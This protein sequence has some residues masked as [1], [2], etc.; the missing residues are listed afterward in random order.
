MKQQSHLQRTSLLMVMVRSCWRLPRSNC[1]LFIKN[2]LYVIIAYIFLNQLPQ[3]KIYCQTTLPAH[4]AYPRTARWCGDESSS[5]EYCSQKCQHTCCYRGI[6]ETFVEPGIFFPIDETCVV[7][8]WALEHVPGS[9][10]KAYLLTKVKSF[11]AKVYMKKCPNQHC[12]ARHS[13]RTWR[14]GISKHCVVENYLYL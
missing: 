8:T 1:C 7:C 12:L 9:N 3:G 14:E 6:Y 11:P 10:T 5:E 2:P 4:W 13:Y